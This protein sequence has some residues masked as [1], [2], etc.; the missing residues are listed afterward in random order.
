MVELLTEAIR[1][2][3]TRRQRLWLDTHA[4]AGVSP[5]VLVREALDAYIAKDDFWHMPLRS[6]EAAEDVAKE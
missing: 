5:S 6:I 4:K 3:L 2:R 1:V